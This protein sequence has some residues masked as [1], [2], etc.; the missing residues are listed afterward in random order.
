M[1]SERRRERGQLSMTAVEAGI[2]VIFV[3]SVTMGFALAVPSPDGHRTQ[4]TIYAEDAT[5]VLAGEPPRHRGTTRL[6]EVIRS[7]AAFERERAE[8]ERRVD[9]I[10][11]ANLLFRVRTPHGSV[12]YRKPADVP[13]GASTVATGRGKVTIWVWYA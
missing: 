4:L 10:L 6:A 5:T 1:D 11:P 3:H 2:G 12:G 7:E 13:V 9:R 8:L